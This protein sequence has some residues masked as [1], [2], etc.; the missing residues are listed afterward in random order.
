M[1]IKRSKWIGS[2]ILGVAEAMLSPAL[3][4]RDP[5]RNQPGAVGNTGPARRA[6][7]RR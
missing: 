5:G 1:N 4:A 7:R 6:V 2:L 3:H